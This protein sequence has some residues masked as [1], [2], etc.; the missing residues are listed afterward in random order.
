MKYLLVACVSEPSPLLPWANRLCVPTNQLSVLKK[1]KSQNVIPHHVYV[2]TVA[3]YKLATGT[4]THESCIIIH[5]SH[6]TPF[7]KQNTCNK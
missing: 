5:M 6:I 7:K 2:L 1:K 3:S 4:G